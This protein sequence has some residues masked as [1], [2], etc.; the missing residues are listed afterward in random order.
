MNSLIRTT[1]FGTVAA[2]ALAVSATAAT[3]MTRSPMRKKSLRPEGPAR[4]R[5]PRWI[6]RA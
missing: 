2:W 5:A 3:A 1:L 6:S 4:C